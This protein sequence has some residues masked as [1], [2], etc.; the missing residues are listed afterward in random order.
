M[1]ACV[2]VSDK[3]VRVRVCQ[4]HVISH[5]KQHSRTGVLGGADEAVLEALLEHLVDLEAH[6]AAGD[7]DDQVGPVQAPH[8][9]QQGAHVLHHLATRRLQRLVPVA[10]AQELHVNMNVNVR[11]EKHTAVA[12]Y[13]LSVRVMQLLF[14]SAGPTDASN[15]LQSTV[16]IRSTS[17]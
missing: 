3:G 7:G 17:I 14:S 4:C 5:E 10:H 12:S 13:V 6:G 2:L 1:K 15:A 9:E 8:L 11:I 16:Y